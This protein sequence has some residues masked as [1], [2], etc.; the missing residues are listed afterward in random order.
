M[1]ALWNLRHIMTDTEYW[2]TVAH[3]WVMTDTFWR[4]S[5]RWKVLLGS[6]RPGCHAMM[7]V[8]EMELFSQLPV[9]VDV[10]RGCEPEK[11]VGFSWSLNVV[12]ARW[13]AMRPLQ[14]GERGIILHGTIDKEKI[15]GVKHE[16]GEFEIIADARDVVIAREESIVVTDKERRLARDAYCRALGNAPTP[17]E[18]DRWLPPT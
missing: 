10:F 18:L 12:I 2:Q 1:K 4:H 8:G 7:D 15:I 5:Y 6:K 3:A 13:F 9:R 11:P 16:I 17:T 14:S